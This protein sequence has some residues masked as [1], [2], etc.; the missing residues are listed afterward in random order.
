MHTEPTTWSRRDRVAYYRIDAARFRRMAE[1]ELRTA[2]VRDR[3][4][5]LARQYQQLADKLEHTAMAAA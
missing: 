5:A 2:M 1:V 4:V 3:L